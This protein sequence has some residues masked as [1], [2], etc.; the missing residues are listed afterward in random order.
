LERLFERGFDVGGVRVGHGLD[1]DGSA[2][3]DLDVANFY[4]V[5]FAPGVARTGGIKPGDLGERGHP[6]KFNKIAAAGCESSLE[7]VH[8][9]T[10]VFDGVEMA[11]GVFDQA[12]G[13]EY[14]G[15]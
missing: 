14:P 8:N 5:G 13:G 6:Y 10:R 1:D 11:E 4:A 15:F 7:T 2:T 3:A 9:L 12:I